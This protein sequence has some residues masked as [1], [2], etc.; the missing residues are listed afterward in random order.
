VHNSTPP[1]PPSGRS[2]F[3]PSSLES[4]LP[5]TQTEREQIAAQLEEKGWTPYRAI[6][7]EAD[8]IIGCAGHRDLYCIYPPPSRACH[9]WPLLAFLLTASDP[10]GGVAP[11]NAERLLRTVLAQKRDKVVK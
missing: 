7:C 8:L 4:P 10:P 5:L 3:G 2:R 11:G 6:D 1:T 9:L